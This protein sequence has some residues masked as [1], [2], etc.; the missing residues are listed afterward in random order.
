MIWAPTAGR[1]THTTTVPRTDGRLV[2]HLTGTEG[3]PT[4]ADYA[5]LN[6]SLIRRIGTLNCGHSAHPI[7]LGVS[8][9]Q[10]SPEELEQMRQMNETGITYNGR[11]YTGYAATQRQRRLEAAMR[12]QKRMQLSGVT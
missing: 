4:D 2:V 12:R 9:P 5:A 6:N 11:H 8:P 7:I 3:R 10:Y 1:S